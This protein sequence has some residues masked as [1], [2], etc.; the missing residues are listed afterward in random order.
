MMKPYYQDEFC[1][2]YHADCREVL[3]TLEPVELVLTD[4]PYGIDYKATQPNAIDY[5][6]VRN[7]DTPFDPALLLDYPFVIIWGANNFSSR[8]PHGGWLVWDK[9]VVEAADRMMG[10]PF[11]LAWS[12]KK[13][14]YKICRLQHGG[15]KNADARNGDVA[16]QKRF[17]PT[18]KPGKL[19][20]WCL[21]LAKDAKTILDPFMGSG[22][23]LRAAKDLGLRAIGI[24]IEE[25]YCEI[26]AKR[27]S[28]QSLFSVDGF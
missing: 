18:Q 24:E 7:D 23:T 21:T 19:M 26:A 10:S 1:T 27:M 16:N 20:K 3:P 12:N 13:A 2:I 8:L 4:P 17:H 25:K 14:L 11:E 5:G 15:A 6:K 9:R 28:Q 22:T